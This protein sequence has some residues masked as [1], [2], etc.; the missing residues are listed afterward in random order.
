[1]AATIYLVILMI[2]F[3]GIVIF[4]FDRRRKARLES[5]ARIPIRDDDEKQH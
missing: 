2:A 4:V 3:I 5:D 1:M